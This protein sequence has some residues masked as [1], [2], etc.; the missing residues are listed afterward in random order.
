MVSLCFQ[1][2]MVV[3]N[4]EHTEMEGLAHCTG[5]DHESSHKK[6]E[7]EIDWGDNTESRKPRGSKIN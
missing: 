4:G 6:R 1:E 2:I 3:G 7:E 5:C